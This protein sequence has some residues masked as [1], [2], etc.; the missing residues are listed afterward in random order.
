[1]KDRVE[2]TSVELQSKRL[3]RSLNASKSGV[4]VSVDEDR[5]AA[6]GECS[7]GRGRKS[8]LE[9]IRVGWDGWSTDMHF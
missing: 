6:G 7:K 1:M 3:S 8:D 5:A 2:V 9:K 4:K